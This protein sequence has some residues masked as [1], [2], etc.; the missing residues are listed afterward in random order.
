MGA[1]HRRRNRSF[2]T[3]RYTDVTQPI[4]II[5]CC[6]SHSCIEVSDTFVSPAVK[7]GSFRAS[8]TAYQMALGQLNLCEHGDVRVKVL[9]NLGSAAAKI[10]ET[11]ADEIDSIDVCCCI[12]II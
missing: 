11:Y 3:C 4:V 8:V 12:W 5:Q 2:Q 10:V 1:S 7:R 9:R 6:Q